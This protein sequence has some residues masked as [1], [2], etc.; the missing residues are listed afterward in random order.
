VIKTGMKLMGNS[1]HM[2]RIRSLFKTSIG[3]RSG[4]FGRSKYKT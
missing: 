1:E 4:L 3:K 2:G